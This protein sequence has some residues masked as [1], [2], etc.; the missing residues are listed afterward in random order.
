LTSMEV[1][2]LDSSAASALAQQAMALDQHAE[3]LG[4]LLGRFRAPMQ[5]I[6]GLVPELAAA[7]PPMEQEPVAVPEPKDNTR[8][9]GMAAEAVRGSEPSTNGERV[10]EVAELGGR[11]LKAAAGGPEADGHVYDLNEF[12]AVEL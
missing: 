7:V 3:A 11:E 2:T 6:R 9:F 12:G 10:Y 1:S 4:E 5:Q 8:D